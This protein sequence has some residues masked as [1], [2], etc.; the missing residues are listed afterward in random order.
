MHPVFL[1]AREKTER[2][3]L[4]QPTMATIYMP[5]KIVDQVTSVSW[6]IWIEQSVLQQPSPTTNRKL[7]R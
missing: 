1:H 7:V 2:W 4:E 5:T 3:M 6:V